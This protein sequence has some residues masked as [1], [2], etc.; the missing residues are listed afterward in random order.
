MKHPTAMHDNSPPFINPD[1]SSRHEA[2]PVDTAHGGIR[3]YSVQR[4]GESHENQDNRPRR[5]APVL[6][7]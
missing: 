5:A 4:K 7:P 1:A 6:R 3:T 2:R